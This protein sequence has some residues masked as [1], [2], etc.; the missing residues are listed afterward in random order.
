MLKVNEELRTAQ[1]NKKGKNV[2]FTGL[3]A[4]GETD[5]TERDA[6]EKLKPGQRYI[7]IDETVLLESADESYKN[8]I[9][10]FFFGGGGKVIDLKNASSAN[11]PSQVTGTKFDI[12]VVE[13]I[14]VEG[15]SVAGNEKSQDNEDFCVCQ[16]VGEESEFSVEGRDSCPHESYFCRESAICPTESLTS[17]SLSETAGNSDVQQSR[18]VERELLTHKEPFK[19]LIENQDAHVQETGECSKSFVYHLL[20]GDESKI[21]DNVTDESIPDD[22]S[23]DDGKVYIVEG[24]FA[25][26][27]K[28]V[29]A[30]CRRNRFKSISSDDKEIAVEKK[31]NPFVMKYASDYLRKK[32]LAIE[33]KEKKRSISD[34]DAAQKSDGEK[35]AIVDNSWSFF[36]IL[37]GGGVSGGVGGSNDTDDSSNKEDGEEGKHKVVGPETNQ[38]VVPFVESA[39]LTTRKSDVNLEEKNKSF[40][41]I[42]MKGSS[43]HPKVDNM[44]IENSSFAGNKKSRDNKDCYVCQSVSEKSEFSV[45]GGGNGSV[46]QDTDVS[47][48]LEEI[49]EV[50]RDFVPD[51][52]L[53][54]SSNETVKFHFEKPPEE[55]LSID[56]YI[57]G[58][59]A[60]IMVS[61]DDT[62]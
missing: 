55:E 11:S 57:F 3:S 61:T 10:Y 41:E 36:D 14:A 62:A 54:E 17:I 27:A 46:Q 1:H 18:P 44:S 37:L 24:I 40:V 15:S 49:D 45:E 59:G 33:E 34:D 56:N 50:Y 31:I 23:E 43:S 19:A 35:V 51:L 20:F 60:K 42:D 39:A 8:S 6:T 53:E 30:I 32:D 9:S 22:E 47:Y 28:E 4:Q 2:Q 16:S 25:F 5:D 52:P 38:H 21:V 26:D 58:G 48:E 13:Q 12:E 29:E 7:A